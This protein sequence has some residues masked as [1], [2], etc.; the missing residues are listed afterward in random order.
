MSSLLLK[1]RKII[2]RNILNVGQRGF[3]LLEMIVALA[4][5]TIALF[6]ATST[7]LSVVNA[8]RKSRGI[9]VA[10]DNLNLALEDISRKIKTGYSYSCDGGATVA[11]CTSGSHS[12]LAFTDQA[13]TRIMYKLGS[14]PGTIVAGTVAS[15]CGTGYAA[16]Q[17]CILRSD[18]GGVSFI[19]ATSPE[20]SITLLK[21]LVGGSAIWPDTQQP[22]V[23]VVV[24][25][26]LGNQTA[27]QVAFRVQTTITQRA[28][29]H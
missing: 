17:G 10:T 7:F 28:Y 22:S 2:N 18:D 23:I 6:I 4:I 1:V 5:F 16:G 21:F 15:G 20:I 8:D 29:D 24:S 19:T 3:T 9:R 25:G 14:G 11:D 27:T 26:S 13:G 12:T